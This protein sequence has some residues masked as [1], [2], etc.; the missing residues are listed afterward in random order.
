MLAT[1]PF[2][3]CGSLACPE[4]VEALIDYVVTEPPE[5]S[6][7]KVKFIYPYKSSE[8]VEPGGA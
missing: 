8:V 5:D 4:Q 1:E 2:R 6:E 7:G 3:I